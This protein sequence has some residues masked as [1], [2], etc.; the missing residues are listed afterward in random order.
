MTNLNPNVVKGR[1]VLSDDLAERAVKGQ[2]KGISCLKEGSALAKVQLKLGL[3]K[4]VTLN[5]KE[6]I[7]NVKSLDKWIA[8]TTENFGLDTIGHFDKKTHDYI[9]EAIKDSNYSLEEIIQNHVRAQTGANRT[10]PREGALSKDR[11]ISLFED[12]AQAYST[13]QQAEEQDF[14]PRLPTLPCRLGARLKPKAGKTD[15]DL[16]SNQAAATERRE[17]HLA[18][19]KETAA[20]ANRKAQEKL[21]LLRQPSKPKQSAWT[22]PGNKVVSGEAVT[23]KTRARQNWEKV[24]TKFKPLAHAAEAFRAAGEKRADKR[25]RKEASKLARKER[26]AAEQ[27]AYAQAKLAKE[28]KFESFV[29]G[30]AHMPKVSAWTVAGNKVVKGEALT[31]ETQAK[32]EAMLAAL[33]AKKKANIALKKEKHAVANSTPWGKASGAAVVR[34]TTLTPQTQAAKL[35]AARSRFQAAGRKVIALIRATEAFKLAGADQK[36]KREADQKRK[37]EVRASMKSKTTFS[38]FASAAR[39]PKTEKQLRA[40][41]LREIENA[42]GEMRRRHISYVNGVKSQPKGVGVEFSDEMKAGLKGRMLEGHKKAV[43]N[44]LLDKKRTVLKP[45]E[46]NMLKKLNKRLK[47]REKAL[48][49][50]GKASLS[51]RIKAEAEAQAE[52][53]KAQE[54]LTTADAVERTGLR[55][56]ANTLTG[57]YLF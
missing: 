28:A 4:K 36:V 20:R 47:A 11:M 48:L 31:P 45:S 51:A 56:L 6:Y 10:Q 57:G 5:G 32:R 53:D 49:A 1:L 42:V 37:D 35:E 34:G 25:E 54:Q 9:R 40:D 30:D 13:Q 22:V 41:H 12:E 18:K 33:E 17:A 19:K 21:A 46:S 23:P 39:Q 16:A 24:R 15:E 3:A 44:E 14:V 7:I 38:S 29:K 26:V 43:L 52:L 27:A 50:E 2:A 8:R 55:W